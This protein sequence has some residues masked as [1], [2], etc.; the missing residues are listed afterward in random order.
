MPVHDVRVYC[1][2]VFLFICLFVC[3]LIFVCLFVCVCVFFCFGF[4]WDVYVSGIGH[5]DT[6][7]LNEIKAVFIPTYCFFFLLSVSMYFCF[8]RL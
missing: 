8:S 6:S 4:S 3:L 2:I 1:L 5:A 7:D